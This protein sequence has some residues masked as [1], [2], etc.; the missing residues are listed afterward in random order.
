MMTTISPA[1]AVAL[2]D[3]RERS[4]KY[5]FWIFL[6]L[7]G[8]ATY[9][10]VPTQEAPYFAVR[11]DSY[12]GLYNSAWVGSQVTLMAVTMLTLVGFYFVR[13]AIAREQRYKTHE[14]VASAPIGNFSYLA[15][16]ALSNFL[17][18][19]SMIA[20]LVVM[21]ALLQLARGED[22]SLD[23]WALIQPYLLIVTPLMFAVSA[24]AVLFDSIALLSG[25]IGNVVFFILWTV[26]LATSNINTIQ[27]ETHFDIFGVRYLWDQMMFGCAAVVSG[28][29]P[30]QGPHSVG[31][32]FKNST[33]SRLTTFVWPGAHWS[34]VFI[35][36]RML[37]IAAA[38]V[39]VAAGSAAFAR[40]DVQR[41]KFYRPSL[42]TAVPADT[43][44][45]PVSEPTSGAGAVTRLTPLDRTARKLGLGR[46]LSAEL[47][48]ALKGVSLWWYLVAAG[49]FLAGLLTPYAITYKF[50]LAGAWFWPLL[51]W[52]ALGCRDQI[53]DTRQI[54]QSTPGGIW[55]QL[56]AQWLAGFLIAVAISGFFGI[57]ALVAGDPGAFTHWLLG[58]AFI[59]SLA[60]TCGIVTGGRKLFEVLYTLIFYAGPLNKTPFC[61]F[62]GSVLYGSLQSS[63]LLWSLITIG[64]LELSVV[65]R[66]WQLRRS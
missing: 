38:G 36:G 41:R 14:L 1:L 48:I 44:L 5:S 13:G 9:L 37:L 22:R 52:S 43:P 20:V 62:T 18:L 25:G 19:A 21:S 27:G 2:A 17:V 57:R 16:K 64:L 3:F 65:A 49:L 40:F 66:N 31:F 54:V 24:L 47:R 28:Y 8:Y 39:F 50:L 11:L 7:I 6:I 32:N 46:I 34:F 29:Q 63:L 33:E 51:I 61:D 55:T 15:G 58:A 53:F 30:W 59:P 4:R 35:I 60:L 56:S 10:F 45:V 12:R 23:I 26:A 42:R